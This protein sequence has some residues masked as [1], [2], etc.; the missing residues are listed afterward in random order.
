MTAHLIHRAVAASAAAALLAA[1]LALPAAAAGASISKY[2][3]FDQPYYISCPFERVEV[4]GTWHGTS[5]EKRDGNGGWHVVYNRG[6]SNA[7]GVGQTTGEVYSIHRRD[8]NSQQLTS[9]TTRT[10]TSRWV[11]KARGESKAAF[12]ILWQQKVTINAD[13]ELI[14]D[15]TTTSVDCTP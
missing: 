7:V 8:T 15:E 1:A 11:G 2:D 13:G 10:F 9:A 4:T 3:F 6:F 14:V 12:E 5:I